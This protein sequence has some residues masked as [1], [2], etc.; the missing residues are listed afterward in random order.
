MI[1]TTEQFIANSKAN[2][3]SLESLT[4]QAC[5][6]VEKLVELNLAT[7]KAVLGESFGNVQ[8]VLDAKSPQEFLAL[9][10]GLLKPLAEKSAAYFQ[11]VQTIATESSAEVTKAVE[12]KMAEAQ[13]S[14]TGVVE[15][16]A[17]NAPAG[18]E[19]AVAAFK[20]A[21]SAGQNAI[22]TAQAS[23]KKVAE[24]AQSNFAAAANQAVNSVKKAT[25]AAK[26]V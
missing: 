14:F 20:S 3:Q 13:K 17:K 26:A 2:L 18:T 11:H 15:N 19:S 8:T 10:S 23:A 5:T 12:A 21:L 22:E 6:G 25:K 7:Y 1:N 24:V 16:L 4:S 9:Q